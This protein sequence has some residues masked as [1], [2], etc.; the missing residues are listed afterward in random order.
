ME[1]IAAQFDQLWW[2][3]AILLELKVDRRQPGEV[4]EVV[5]SMKWPGGR[6][7]AIRFLDCFGMIANLNFGIIASESVLTASETEEAGPFKAQYDSWLKAGLALPNLK[8]FTI[9]TNSTASL[10]HILA[11]GWREEAISD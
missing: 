11:R 8:L 9:E 5:V 3:D 4:D 7:S 6:K 1:V 10:L 2:H